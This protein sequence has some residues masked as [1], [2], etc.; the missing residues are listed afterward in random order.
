MDRHDFRKDHRTMNNKRFSC[1]DAG[2]A[3]VAAARLLSWRRRLAQPGR[4]TD[5]SRR[6][7]SSH[8]AAGAQSA[9]APARGRRR[10]TRF[11][12]R[13]REGR[14]ARRRHDSCRRQGHG[15]A[16]AVS[17]AIQGDEF[18]RRFFGDQFGPA[19]IR[20]SGRSVRATF[21]QRGLG[22]GVIVGSDGYILTN[23]HVVDGADN[24]HVDLTDGRTLD[25]KVVGT[26]KPSDLALDQG[27]A[28]P[29][30]RRCRS[31]I[32]TPCRSATSC[33]RSAIRSASARR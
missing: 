9:V 16:D 5:V 7:P 11:V 13:H 24:I 12:R 17:A 26:D 23:H 10:R 30:C 27:D 1:S 29:T 20:S 25:A 31:A 19:T 4:S 6:S 28:R 32:P 18:F 15:V 2:V 33:S 3:A 21:R 14:R 8:A 22:S